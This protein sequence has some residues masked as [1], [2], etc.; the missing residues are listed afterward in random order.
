MFCKDISVKWAF[1]PGLIILIM[2]LVSFPHIHLMKHNFI[3]DTNLFLINKTYGLTAA[4]SISQMKV[5]VNMSHVLKCDTCEQLAY[6]DN[7]KIKMM[8]K[9]L[10]EYTSKYFETI[11]P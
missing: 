9:T 1:L 7:G 5:P 3:K 4:G 8:H 10:E 2:I 11:Y 6:Y